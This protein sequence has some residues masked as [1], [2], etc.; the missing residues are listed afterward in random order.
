M[1]IN[2]IDSNT[3]HPV[4]N[5]TKT[6][7]S[8]GGVSFGGNYATAKD[9]KNIISVIDKYDSSRLDGTIQKFYQYGDFMVKAPDKD[10]NNGAIKEFFALARLKQAHVAGS[11][12]PGYATLAKKGSR[13]FLVEEYVT[14]QKTSLFPYSIR[15]AREDVHIMAQMDRTGIINQ[16]ISPTNIFI[17]PTKTRKIIDFDTYS[18]LSEEGKVL[19]SQHTAPNYYTAH[20]PLS[21]A[22]NPKKINGDILEK[23]GRKIE[24]I[25]ADSFLYKKKTSIGGHDLINLKNLSPNPYI[26]LPSNITNYEARTIYSR[27]ISADIDNPAKFLREYLVAKSDYHASMRDFLQGL[28]IKSSADETIVD[29]AREKLRNAIDY[30]DFMS[31]LFKEERPDPYFAKLEAAKIQLH[32]L[33]NY[34]SAQDPHAAEKHLPAAYQKLITVIHDGLDAYQE[35]KYQRYLRAELERYENAFKNTKLGIIRPKQDIPKG[36]DILE[37][38][39][40]GVSLKDVKYPMTNEE[41]IQDAESAVKSFIQASGKGLSKAEISAKKAEII[42]ERV[43]AGIAYNESIAG[44]QIGVNSDAMISAAIQRTKKCGASYNISRKLK[45]IASEKAAEELQNAEY[46]LKDADDTVMKHIKQHTQKDYIKLGGKYFAWIGAA[47]LVG[48]IVLKEF[49][50][51]KQ[52][53]KPDENT[54]QIIEK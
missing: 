39:F 17:T 31:G 51:Y 15:D 14:G 5:K 3:L 8:K 49:I 11:V 30:E 35:P 9:L 25:F 19:H 21:Q 16:D 18:F 22:L 27:M 43:A 53:N 28:K 48:A 7:L 24:E 33:L 42:R 20:T 36:L 45:K 12:V 2:S 44:E 32:G 23:N 26:N 10:I 46:T 1:R 41:I 37:T 54:F 6:P 34:S 4:Y 50:K 38:W 52:E 40:G 29:A 47:A 13:D